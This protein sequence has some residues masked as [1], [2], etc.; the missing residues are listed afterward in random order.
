MI[1]GVLPWHPT[2][3]Q[4]RLLLHTAAHLWLSDLFHWIAP[5][6]LH[7]RKHS[8]RESWSCP[9]VSGVHRLHHLRLRPWHLPTKQ[10]GALHGSLACY[11]CYGTCKLETPGL[12]GSGLNQTGCWWFGSGIMK[13]TPSS[14]RIWVGKAPG[15][16]GRDNVNPWRQRVRWVRLPR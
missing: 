14:H 6:S 11:V 15:C 4:K 2:N 1:H 16:S 9:A 7:Q 8:C 5:N 13:P 10:P 12:W 3:Y